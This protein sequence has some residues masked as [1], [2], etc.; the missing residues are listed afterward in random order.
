MKTYLF[1]IG[2]CASMIAAAVFSLNSLC[3]ALYTAPDR[4]NVMKFQSVP[5]SI[6][7][8][9]FGSSHGLYG[10]NYESVSPSRCCFN[11][12]LVSQ[13]LDYDYRLCQY[14]FDNLQQGGTAFLVISYRSIFGI[15]E[16]EKAD[17][18]SLNQRYYKFLPRRYIKEYSFA[19]AITIRYFPSITIRGIWV[20]AVKNAVQTLSAHE[21]AGRREKG[22]EGSVS[23]D[24]WD[25]SAE[26][27]D[28]KAVAEHNAYARI[29]IS[30][31]RHDGV[32]TR[33]EQ[34]VDSLYHLIALLQ[35]KQIRVCLVTTPFL[36]EYY[37]AVHNLAGDLDEKFYR[38]IS[39]IMEKTGVEYYDYS[40]DPR[41]YHEYSLFLDSD[42]LNREGAKLFTDI[43]LNDIAK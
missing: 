19:E 30:L 12:A 29:G 1:K 18:K 13:S 38:V 14:Y 5:A 31:E 8:F 33:N 6:E 27:L 35:E 24:M 15:D 3:L 32:L 10:F 22:A 21:G 25:A 20:P 39:E 16:T 36:S 40:A 4:D 34:E 37:D 9:N 42:H 17:F 23:A 2:I 11:F 7:L 41:F 28:V 43:L 26:D